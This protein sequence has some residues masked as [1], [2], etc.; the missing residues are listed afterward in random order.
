MF[1][2]KLF[3]FLILVFVIGLG[4]S[5]ILLKPLI[6]PEEQPEKEEV[7]SEEFIPSERAIIGKIGGGTSP[8][9]FLKEVIIDPFRVKQGEKQTFSIW[10]K[11]PK[12]IEKVIG[13]IETDVGEEIIEF[14]LVQG[15]AED[16]RWQGSWITRDISI[17]SIYSIL[18]QATNTEGKTNTLSPPWHVEK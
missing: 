8:P 12:G 1:K 4:I 17:S 11:D 10:V 18:I 14:Q 9:L 13:K 6:I 16:G 7:A 2:I 3:L 5:S 15:I